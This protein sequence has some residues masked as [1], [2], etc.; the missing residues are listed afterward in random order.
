[1]LKRQKKLFLAQAALAT[2]LVLKGTPLKAQVLCAEI[3]LTQ[4]LKSDISFPPGDGLY[5]EQLVR[6]Y[7]AL[8]IRFNQANS[9]ELAFEGVE[10]KS[11]IDQ[12]MTNAKVYLDAKNIKSE[13]YWEKL[14]NNLG[15]IEESPYFLILPTA[16]ASPLNELA[17]TL[18]KTYQSELRLNPIGMMRA[19]ALGSYDFRAKAFHLPLHLAFNKRLDTVTLHEM[20]H[21]M[22]SI[23]LEKNQNSLL[24][25]SLKRMSSTV[26]PLLKS[27]N[28]STYMYNNFFFADEVKAFAKQALIELYL[29]SKGQKS[30]EQYILL[31]AKS[32]GAQ[33]N[34]LVK[35][36]TSVSGQIS[37]SFSEEESFRKPSVSLLIQLAHEM[38]SALAEKSQSLSKDIFQKP[39]LWNFD[40]GIP[41][42]LLESGEIFV[43]SDI[44]GGQLLIFTSTKDYQITVRAQGKLQQTM[45]EALNRHQARLQEIQN[46]N[47]ELQANGMAMIDPRYDRPLLAIQYEFL[48]QNKI[49]ILET[50]LTQN[51]NIQELM[52]QVAPLLQNAHYQYSVSQKKG[53]VQKL[54]EALRLI[55]DFEKV[56][57]E[58]IRESR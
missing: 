54:R 10:K 19:T 45:K 48:S 57:T 56:K 7:N 24:S 41:L 5:L 2:V 47:L 29:E 3:F 23:R 30:D 36:F 8:V 28:V 9:K 20:V 35:R 50:I 42:Y 15:E 33:I 11:Q 25:Y 55:I 22:A 17:T 52:S 13:I 49:L 51:Q 40:A 1:M 39:V 32:A 21:M 34:T 6:Q 53:A 46:R 18:K 12:F 44:S 38:S 26:P 43:R 14:K 4:A 37:S 58:N 16:T 31:T 27:E